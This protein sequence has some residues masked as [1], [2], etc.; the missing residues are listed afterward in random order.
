M[1]DKT[2]DHFAFEIYGIYILTY[3]FILIILH[4]LHMI[5]NMW[6]SFL[7]HCFND[8]SKYAQML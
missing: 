6:E 5:T 8:G 1:K 3:D 2:F 7:V 4:F